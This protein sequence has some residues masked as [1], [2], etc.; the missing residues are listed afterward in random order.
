[1]N[2]VKF[3]LFSVGIL[4]ALV[5]TFGCASSDEGGGNGEQSNIS[6]SKE[7]SSS[8]KGTGKSSSSNEAENNSSSSGTATGN[9]SYSSTGNSS[10]SNGNSSSNKASN[11]SVVCDGYCLWADGCVRISTDPTG[12]YG[13]KIPTCDAATANCFTNSPSRSVFT[14]PNCGRATNPGNS[15][16]SVPKGS[17]TDSR[18]SK[19]Y[20]TVKIGTQTWMMAN[21]NYDAYDGRGSE[22][23]KSC[24]EYGRL[25]DWVTALTACP[26]GWHLPS[27][28][29]WVVLVNYVGGK[30][31][32]GTKLKATSGWKDRRTSCNGTD[33]YG[34]AAL[35][36]GSG[37]Y[38]YGN[39]FDDGGGWWSA[40]EA[41]GNDYLWAYSLSIG[42]SEGVGNLDEFDD[43]GISKYT[44]NGLL[45]VRCLQD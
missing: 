8:S 44:K 28:D 21:L 29:E 25:Y 5:F 23:H 11:G 45:S 42:C 1:M 17:F 22:C 27:Y 7:T 39:S 9:S 38:S 24:S 13:T 41:E 31:T 19:S 43:D 18:D 15:T 4:L 26:D 10:S 40:T 34:F 36:G 32:A 35:P 20:N 37:D 12:E 16:S 3:V 30:W 14:D 6:S 2:K 33:D